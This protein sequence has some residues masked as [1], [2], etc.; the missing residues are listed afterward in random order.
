MIRS[1]L[2]Q[3]SSLLPKLKEDSQYLKIKIIIKIKKKRTSNVKRVL[4]VKAVRDNALSERS[5]FCLS[6]TQQVV[7]Q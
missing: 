7:S 1:S 3:G 6:G 5:G 2:N 4:P